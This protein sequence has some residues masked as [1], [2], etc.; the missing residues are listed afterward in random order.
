M[1]VITN[2]HRARG[3]VGW[4]DETKPLSGLEPGLD[5]AK[6]R[7]V[8]ALEPQMVPILGSAMFCNTACDGNPAGVIN[9]AA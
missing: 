4:L 3:I 5:L 8:V 6:G 2:A 9:K 7:M 1:T